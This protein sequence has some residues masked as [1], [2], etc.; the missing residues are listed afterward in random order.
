MRTNYLIILYSLLCI[1]RVLY[2][3]LKSKDNESKKAVKLSDTQSCPILASPWVQEA[4]QAT[5]ATP[6]RNTGVGS[7]SLLHGI[8]PDQQLNM[9][10][11]RYRQ[12]L[13]HLSYHEAQVQ[14][15]M[16]QEASEW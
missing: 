3:L 16:C 9:G 8:F 5:R 7:R 10:L 11:L 2:R 12:I 13:Y 1:F 15:S 6:G 4:Y 14:V